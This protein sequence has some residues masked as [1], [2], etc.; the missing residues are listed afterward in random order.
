MPG[1]VARLRPPP[2]LLATAGFSNFGFFTAFSGVQGR[3]D[4]ILIKR[5]KRFS[6]TSFPK[7]CDLASLPQPGPT[8]GLGP[9]V[10]SFF[11]PWSNVMSLLS[12]E[13]ALESKVE[14]DSAL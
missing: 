14:T 10:K 1:D 5:F 3:E 8:G 7:R 13:P 11:Y 6:P 12:N 4:E 2:C 9:G